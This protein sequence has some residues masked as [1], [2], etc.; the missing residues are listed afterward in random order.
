[1]T[2]LIVSFRCFVNAPKIKIAEN[3]RHRAWLLIAFWILRIRWSF[4]KVR[5]YV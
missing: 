3:T 2:N 5:I 1:M 4:I